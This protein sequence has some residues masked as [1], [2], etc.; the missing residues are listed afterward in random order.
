MFRLISGR[1]D[2]CQLLD[3]IFWSSGTGNTEENIGGLKESSPALCH[4]KSGLDADSG[5]RAVLTARYAIYNK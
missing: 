4:T 2:T 3:L 5:L 1:V